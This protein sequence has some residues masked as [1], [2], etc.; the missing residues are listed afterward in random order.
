MRLASSLAGISLA[1]LAV[2]VGCGGDLAP[3]EYAA[4]RIASTEA[5]LSDDCFVDDPTSEHKSNF[6][7]GSTVLVYNAPQADEDEF[8]LDVGGIVLP[9]EKNDDGSYAFTGQESDIEDV[10]GQQIFDSDH[11]G[12]ED[13]VDPLVDSDNDGLDD[14]SFADDIEVDVDMD[15]VDDRQQNLLDQDN[16]GI[17]DRITYLES[18]TKVTEKSTYT[19]DLVPDGDRVTGTFVVSTTRTCAGSQCAGFDD[20]KCK[21]TTE[22]VGVSVDPE[23]VAV[24]VDNDDAV[25]N[26]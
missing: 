5:K 4:Y 20:F 9:G 18:D 2:L 8:F 24:P 25:P 22:F 14:L 7:T 12:I 17:D 26:P 21:A 6:R 23:S 11:D 10:G 1:S 16:D 3:G 15:G 19:V 13:T